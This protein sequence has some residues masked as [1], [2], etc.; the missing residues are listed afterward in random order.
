MLRSMS[1]WALALSHTAD[2]GVLAIERAD[3]WWLIV[4]ALARESRHPKICRGSTSTLHVAHSA[5]VT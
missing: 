1:K 3:R 5:S 4:P 2:V